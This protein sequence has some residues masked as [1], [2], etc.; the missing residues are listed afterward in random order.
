[1]TN[2]PKITD[3]ESTKELLDTVKFL[4]EAKSICE[5]IPFSEKIFPKFENVL[6]SFAQLKDQTSILLLPDKFNELFS[7]HGWIAYESMSAEVIKNAIHLHETSGLDV[8]DAYLAE[9]YDEAI[10]NWGIMRFTSYFEFRRRMRLAELA[11]IDYLEG[12]YHACVPLLLSLLDGIVNDVSKHVGFFAGNTNLTAWDCIAG[13]ETGL[14][15]LAGLLNKG[16]NKTSEDSITIPYRNGILHGRDLAFDNKIVAAKC[17][18]ALFAIRDWASALQDGKKEASH[19]KELSWQEFFSKINETNQI[20]KALENWKAR[21]VSD[22]PYL[23][24]NGNIS[25]LPSNTPEA[26][27]GRFINNWQ[28]KRFGPLSED[29]LNYTNPSQGI[30]AG[31]A[32][33]DFSKYTPT[34]YVILDVNDETSAIS[35]V[36][37]EFSFEIESKI[38]NRNLLI[39]MCYV[40]TENNL[41]PRNFENG[42]WQI[43]QNSFSEVIYNDNFSQE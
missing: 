29:L 43:I 14:Q 12:R 2:K 35:N 3:N 40:D 17:W 21:S 20:N 38:I 32:K 10:L 6:S 8:A 4:D 1:M 42:R 26:I 39:R 25:E 9:T 13:H 22:M 19:K 16:R 5:A 33:Q 23:P 27:V 31:R 34:S 7:T 15:N 30:K 11:K 41:L 37:V 36:L 24:F 28:A 18:A